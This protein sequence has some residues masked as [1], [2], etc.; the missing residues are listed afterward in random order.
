MLYLKFKN[1]KLRKILLKNEIQ[2]KINKFLFINLLS[3]KKKILISKSFIK[4][5]EYSLNKS[6]VKLTNRCI[7]N[8]R[9]RG[10]LRSYNIS[11]LFIKDLLE[12]GIVPGFKKAVW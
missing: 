4:M 12:F 2:R 3:Q 5:L 11:R 6:K 1:S 7:F 8:N 10:V 9:N